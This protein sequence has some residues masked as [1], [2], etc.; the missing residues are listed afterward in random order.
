MFLGS[1]AVG[2][3]AAV[4]ANGVCLGDTVAASMRPHW[5][6]FSDTKQGLLLV[7]GPF[8]PAALSLRHGAGYVVDTFPQQPKKVGVT[9]PAP[10]FIWLAANDECGHWI[11]HV[12]LRE[13]LGPILTFV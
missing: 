4:S 9:W 11:G 6:F 12:T 7:E 13:R 10:S 5:I 8:T 2:E 1:S 3:S